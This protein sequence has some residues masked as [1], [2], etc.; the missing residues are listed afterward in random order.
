M[1][2]FGD[3]LLGGVEKVGASIGMLA[4]GDLAGAIGN[5][6]GGEAA[7]GAMEFFGRINNFFTNSILPGTLL[8][9]EAGK[10][11]LDLFGPDILARLNSMRESVGALFSGLTERA[12][13]F[14]DGVLTKFSMWIVENGPLLSAFFAWIADGV[15]NLVPIV[16]VA[17]DI[18]MPLLGGVV[19]IILNLATLIM[20]VATGDWAGAWQTIQNIVSVATAAIGE[21]LTVFLN[22]IAGLFGSSLTEIGAIWSENW[23]LFVEILGKLK[24]IASKKINEFIA[25][26]KELFNVDWG[27]VGMNII[28]GIAAGIS[29]GVGSIINAARDAAKAALSAAKDALGI[30][31]PSTEAEEQVG[32]P[33]AEGIG[34]GV[35]KQEGALRNSL[36]DMLN[37]AMQG[38]GLDAV[39]VGLQPAPAMSMA[40]GTTVVNIYNNAPLQIY[41]EYSLENMLT[42]VVDR[43]VSRKR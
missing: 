31:S 38:L 17:I 36:A 9:K 19:D 37:N 12:G 33:L 22:W 2:A 27:E 5:L 29:G 35:R 4:D 13:P 20:Q 34:V 18:I 30:K 10:A 16:L 25:R 15:N 8:L 24:D 40:G 32:G 1:T 21:S 26:I 6:F 28:A 41:D 23:M 7:A 42:P 3:K 14:I 39:P 43:I 11:F